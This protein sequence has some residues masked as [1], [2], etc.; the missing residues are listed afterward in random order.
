VGRLSVALVV[1]LAAAGL[2][3]GPLAPADAVTNPADAVTNPADAVTNPADAVTSPPGAPSGVTT[4]P[5]LSV[6]RIPGW[7]AQ[8]LAG[9]R[10]ATKL[11]ALLTQPSLG[12]AARASCLVVNQ[13]ART[14]Y[15]E[16]PELSL[17]PASNMKLLTATAV[18]DRLG[19]AHRLTT[20]VVGAHPRAGVV[21]GNLYLVGG[22]DPLLATRPSATGL[23]SGQTLY[24]SLDQ[25]AAQVPAAGITRVTGSVVGD[26][27]RYDQARTVPTWEPQYAA[28]GDVA[29]LSALE[30]NDGAPPAS[31]TPAGTGA[32]AAALAAATSADPAARAAATFNQVLT[33]AGVR[34]VGPPTTGKAPSGLPVL[35]SLASPPLAAEVDA[36]LTV[37]DDTAAELFTKELGT[38]TVHRGT[39]TAGVGAIRADLAADGLS[40]SQL[41][42]YD[43]SGLD[44]GDR[45]TCSLIQADLERAGPNSVIGRGLPVAGQT[46]TL[47]DRMRGTPA[48]GRI[49]AKTGT[50]DG[51]AALSGFVLPGTGT[52]APGSVL[53]EPIVFSLILNQIP[54][55]AAGRAVG[56]QVGVALAAYPK[57]PPLADIEPRP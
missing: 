5:V 53:G 22:G 6:R 50:L 55:E 12:G 24:T 34:V 9:Q 1:V 45:A 11:S 23:G 47:S 38:D 41:V 40:V 16:R 27:S 18:L 30:V 20:D 13:G 15:A 37:S 48:A 29:P 44:R 3:V 2:T 31:P 32:S 54:S 33:A 19:A 14:L 51:V 8:T 17:I 4:T 57:L 43:G 28:E 35:T 39:T 25:L 7:V 52:R 21:D 10:L 42:A 56:D 46:G 26:E 49:R 36:M